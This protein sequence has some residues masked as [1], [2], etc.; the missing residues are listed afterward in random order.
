MKKEKLNAQS[1]T[2]TEGAERGWDCTSHCLGKRTESRA[3]RKLRAFLPHFHEVGV[4]GMDVGSQG[5]SAEGEEKGARVGLEGC[6][7]PLEGKSTPHASHRSCCCLWGLK[8]RTL[9]GLPSPRGRW[10]L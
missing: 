10:V 2:H 7:R 8:P 6:G 5:P 4:W 3:D 1:N 9:E